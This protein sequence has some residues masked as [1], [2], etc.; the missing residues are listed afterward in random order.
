MAQF[1]FSAAIVSRSAA[2][3]VVAA[4]AYRAG[5]KLRDERTGDIK[6]YSGRSWSVL[7]TLILTPENAPQWML[8]RLRLWNEVERREDLSTKRDTAQLA[9]NIEL[10]LP[11]ELTHEQHVQLVCEFVK[12]EFVDRGM[13]ADIAIH[14][15]PKRGDGTNHHA[16]I[17]LTMRDVEDGGF[18]AKNRDWNRK[19]LI[20]HWRER[21]AE[22]QN[23]ALEK[24]GH[25]ARVDHRSL[26]DQGLDRQPTTHLGPNL[27]AM[28]DAGIHTDRGDQNRRIKAANDNLALA[29]RDLAECDKRI[30]E[31]RRQL[32]VERM[33]EIQRT[34]RA[35][36]A[37]WKK[38]GQRPAP[39]PER[40]PEPEPPAPTPRP[41]RPSAAERMEQIQKTVQAV[42][43]FWNKPEGRW[44]PA[45]DLPPE[46]EPPT[47]TQP[48][49]PQDA[50]KYPKSSGPPASPG[51]K[52]AP[53]P[54]D[55]SKQQELAAQQEAAR[56]KQAQDDEQ[57]RQKQAAADQDRTAEAA[58]EEAQ[59]QA[60]ARQEEENR[61]QQLRDAE[62]KRVEAEA[63]QNAERQAA[64]AEEMRL[65][66]QR[67]D[68][69][70]AK[71][72]AYNA[73][74]NRIAQEDKR[75]QEAERQARL[76]EKAREGPIRE[77]SSRYAQALGQH[78]DIRDPYASLAKS[79][80]AEYAA[81]RRD[82]EAYDQQIAQTADPIERQALDLRK[83]IEG[84]EYLALTGDRIAAQSEIIT[85]RLNSDEAKRQRGRATEYRIQ[86]QDLRQQ[87]RDLRR[88]RAPE[89]DRE[90]EPSEPQPRPTRARHPRRRGPDRYDELIKQQDDQA[91]AKE[92]GKG[93]AQERQTQQERERELQ[94]KR[95]RER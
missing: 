61:L 30:E 76:A 51:G 44:P 24:Y 10:S 87:L 16:H 50:S 79:A 3:S 62:N 7:Y 86:A 41:P 66:Q 5:E 67:L 22:Y 89:K 37:F 31:L 29:K 52:A 81:F 35:A 70:Q 91:K 23:R 90:R 34:V 69:Q 11:H 49:Q 2:Q 48:L 53:M 8:D 28:E 18:G 82:R 9:R 14:A 26:E 77:A 75:K 83:R 27:Q 54:D 84:A 15:P 68:A 4:A 32:A 43:A 55:L 88:E 59:R 38:E 80:M 42:D 45:P 72:D 39:A 57:A 74:L 19:A 93:K 12:A 47:P 36:D 17:L 63:K 92:L 6:D 85:G 21:W 64:Q 73:E 65:A 33:E 78:Y 94:R 58:K 56:Q 20:E 71:I 13:V 25:E 95:D 60:Q 46:P 40:P 1:R